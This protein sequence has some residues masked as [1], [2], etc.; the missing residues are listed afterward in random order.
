MNTDMDA[1]VVLLANKDRAWTCVFTD[2]LR[3]DKKILSY[4]DKMVFIALKSYATL[5]ENFNY[6]KY[7]FPG[8]R[9]IRE[10]T[11]ISLE[12]IDRSLDRLENLGF[13]KRIKHQKGQPGH[14]STLYILNDSAQMCS[15]K[16]AEEAKKISQ[17]TEEEFYAE[18]LR[19]KGW[20][21]EPPQGAEEEKEVKAEKA[22][23]EETKEKELPSVAADESSEVVG[24][25]DDNDNDQNK[26][27]TSQNANQGLTPNLIAFNEM[28]DKYCYQVLIHDYPLE[29][30]LIN[31]VMTKLF[32]LRMS[33]NPTI[34]I[35]G[36]T[37]EADYVKTQLDKLDHF[38]IIDAIHAFQEASKQRKIK[39]PL[40]YL[41]KCIWNNISGFSTRQ[42]AKYNNDS[43]L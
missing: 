25:V 28:L 8:V 39:N 29:L 23:V 34:K 9:A 41:M 37:F 20:T 31:D 21:V 7:P 15:A 32:E 22:V 19:K 2:F 4:F 13:L 43:Y 3:I 18:M 16:T 30:C 24:R 42:E 1:G 40:G 36:D 11:G 26:D 38:M 35:G 14:R 27:N 33:Q 17:M 6:K 5:D 12:V 10:D